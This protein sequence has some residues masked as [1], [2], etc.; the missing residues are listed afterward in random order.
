[1]RDWCKITEVKMMGALKVVVTFD[2]RES[3]LMA[4]K[5][6]FLLN[7]FI[8]VRRWSPGESNIARRVWLEIYGLPVHVWNEPNMVKVGEVWGKVI[9]VKVENEEHYNKFNVLVDIGFGSTIQARLR[10]KVEEEEFLLYTREIRDIRAF[11]DEKEIR[12]TKTVETGGG[13]AEGQSDGHQRGSGGA[14]ETSG[15]NLRE[16]AG[17]AI[18]TIAASSDDG[19]ADSTEPQ[20]AHETK[21]PD[22]VEDTQ[23]KTKTW[24]DDKL[25]EDVVRE[26]QLGQGMKRVVAQ[27]K[28]KVFAWPELENTV[29]GPDVPP[30]F[31]PP[32]CPEYGADSEQ[33]N[34]IE[35]LVEKQGRAQKK[36][37]KR[38]RATNRKKTTHKPE[39]K[40]SNRRKREKK[41]VTVSR[42]PLS[43][44]N[45]IENEEVYDSEREP[46]DS[47][48]KAEETWRVGKDSGMRTENDAVPCEFLKED[49]EAELCEDI[50]KATLR[51]R[52][53]KKKNRKE[54]GVTLNCN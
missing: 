47:N 3:M 46:Q 14:K 39:S 25:T 4:E 27:D 26:T 6:P 33:E 22:D 31:D 11:E 9:R 50:D 53:R 24:N 32:P 49:E 23:S 17:K 8:E 38:V 16:E 44:A 48:D 43:D 30:G 13:G 41:Q 35:N 1:M 12:I 54:V 10:I 21:R 7:H 36:E 2:S 52:G 5:S 42:R 19:L 37:T 28:N 20:Q 45:T 18:V 51:R 34:P 29:S 15:E 40:R